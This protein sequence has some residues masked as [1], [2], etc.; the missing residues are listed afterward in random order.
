MP[1]P[2]TAQC[3]WKQHKTYIFFFIV[4]WYKTFFTASVWE[5]K[6]H[7]LGNKAYAQPALTENR[8]ISYVFWQKG[9]NWEDYVYYQ[10]KQWTF[11]L[12]LNFYNL[13]REKVHLSSL[14]KG[15]RKRY[16]SVHYT[17]RESKVRSRQKQ[18]TFDS[19]NK[20]LLQG[21]QARSP[22]GISEWLWEQSYSYN[23]EKELISHH[24]KFKDS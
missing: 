24:R 3:N 21:L 8:T 23:N 1:M 15:E 18:I 22:S 13:M 2:N 6:V 14:L 4:S 5:V 19:V 16:K 10:E 7:S 20:S 17:C 11:H 12:H 9:S